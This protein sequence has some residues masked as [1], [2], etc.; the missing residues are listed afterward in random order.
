MTDVIRALPEPVAGPQ[1]RFPG[2]WHRVEVGDPSSCW[3]WRG[4][5]NDGYGRLMVNRR[6][7]YAYH[8]AYELLVGEV[9]D[10]MVL[11]HLCRNRACCNPAHLEA[12]TFAENVLRGE[13]VGARAAR[14]TTCVNG[15][16]LSAVVEGGK[17]R[18]RCLTCARASSVE[19][20][21][22]YRDRQKAVAA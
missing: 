16:A 15:H 3:L 14:Q 8:L 4:H 22:R 6:N 18:R 20:S 19:R 5:L 21:R 13:G 12:V 9:P 10:G 11:D 2:F 17:Q 1:S 7:V